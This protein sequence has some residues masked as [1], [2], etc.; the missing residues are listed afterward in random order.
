MVVAR[1]FV[2]FSS[3]HLCCRSPPPR[4]SLWQ[5][6]QAGDRIFQAVRDIAAMR[7]EDTLLAH[8]QEGDWLVLF[9]GLFFLSALPALLPS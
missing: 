5:N 1:S 3:G 9:S 6:R 4:L 8:I 7:P 2:F